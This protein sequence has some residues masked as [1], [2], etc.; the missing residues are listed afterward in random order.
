MKAAVEMPTVRQLVHPQF[1]GDRVP[2]QHPS[3][4]TSCTVTP[5]TGRYG[6]RPHCSAALL[7]ALVEVEICATNQDRSVP[8][9]TKSVLLWR[10]GQPHRL[11]LQ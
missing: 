10:R 8:G 3:G 11:S 2:I 6:G 7:H 1:G 9:T 5:H 4:H